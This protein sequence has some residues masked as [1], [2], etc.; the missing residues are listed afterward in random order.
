MSILI[1]RETSRDRQEPVGRLEIPPAAMRRGSR[2]PK[3][4]SKRSVDALARS[5]S[6]G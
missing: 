6:C 1:E 4:A 3:C 5:T 2:I